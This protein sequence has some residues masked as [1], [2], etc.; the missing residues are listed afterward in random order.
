M[1][2]KTKILDIIKNSLSNVYTEADDHYTSTI[3]ANK[4]TFDPSNPNFN[5]EDDE[6]NKQIQA[7]NTDVKKEDLLKQVA[8]KINQSLKN[9]DELNDIL[10]QIKN[11]K[12]KDE[13]NL[14]WEINEAGNTATLGNKNARI[15]KQNNNLCVSYK[16]KIEIFKSV[17]ELHDWL[18]KNDL[19]LPKNIKLHESSPWDKILNSLT[20]N[21]GHKVGDT[22]PFTQ[23][24][25]EERMSKMQ[26]PIVKMGQA[27][28][29]DAMKFLDKKSDKL[30]KPIKGLTADELNEDQLDNQDLWYLSY[31][32]N[33]RDTDFYLNSEWM[34]GNLLTDNLEQAAKFLNK[35]EAKQEAEKV[36][37]NKIIDAPFIPIQINDINECFGGTT[38]ASIGMAPV[39]TSNKKLKEEDELEEGIYGYP[40]TPFEKKYYDRKYTRASDYLKWYNSLSDD[41]KRN[42]DPNEENYKLAKE[43]MAAYQ[44]RDLGAKHWTG[45]NVSKDDP[46]QMFRNLIDYHTGEI[47]DK[48]LF[49]QRVKEMNDKYG[50]DINPNEPVFNIKNPDITSEHKW[51][52]QISDHNKEQRDKWIKDYYIPNRML[53]DK[54]KI[55]KNAA[56]RKKEYEQELIDKNKNDS[57]LNNNPKIISFYNELF[58]MRNDLNSEQTQYEFFNELY[59]RFN[60]LQPAEQKILTKKLIDAGEKGEI[61]LDDTMLMVLNDRLKYLQNE[62]VNNINIQKTLTEDD[63]PEDFATNKSTVNVSS[64]IDTTVNDNKDTFS[65]PTEA[66]YT[67]DIDSIGGNESDNPAVNFGDISIDGGS[68]DPDS[69]EEQMDIPQEPPYKIVDVLINDSD[70]S[71]IKVKVQNTETEEIETKDLSEINI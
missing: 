17:Q 2:N 63:K 67:N 65:D 16:N 46:D 25:R 13:K 32:T 48:D 58:D 26:K 18:R 40:G 1:K 66:E 55:R 45:R 9:A 11:L 50:L 71:D 44:G 12:D 42:I 14:D 30:Q 23:E 47:L 37:E 19:P 15:F 57:I 3:D 36:Y 62:A 20:T 41:G 59:K 34:E 5:I 24:E 6:E 56:S 54:G 7:D 70:P 21:D 33:N 52:K 60:Q 61:D 35:E 29:K 39:Y 38:S 51:I 22:V 43:E 49:I 53:G 10:K 28:Y 69:E 31:Q 4:S 27:E 64:D 68:I 8:N